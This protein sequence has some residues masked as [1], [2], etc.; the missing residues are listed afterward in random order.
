[1]SFNTVQEAY[2]AYNKSEREKSNKVDAEKVKIADETSRLV[3]L[4]LHKVSTNKLVQTALLNSIAKNGKPDCLVE[5]NNSGEL[6]LQQYFGD[7][8][9]GADVKDYMVRN[10][11]N[12]GPIYIHEGPFAGWSLNF[13]KDII[14]AGDNSIRVE[15]DN[16]SRCSI[17]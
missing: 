6:V 9:I 17:L 1:M 11:T 5:T 4:I 14:I 15:L 8:L 16:S 7:C 3:N 13:V 12:I 10:Y 2:D